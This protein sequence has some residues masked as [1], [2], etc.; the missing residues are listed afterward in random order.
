M[1]FRP[2]LA[3]CLFAVIGI[4]S[5]SQPARCLEVIPLL[6]SQSYVAL[7]GFLGLGGCC[8]SGTLRT[9]VGGIV[10]SNFESIG[11]W[12]VFGMS[13]IK[14]NE[15]AVLRPV[16]LI[17]EEVK[18]DPNLDSSTQ[19]R[20]VRRYTL[21]WSYGVGLFTHNTRTREFDLATLVTGISAISHFEFQYSLNDQFSLVGV[22][23]VGAGLSFDDQGAILN[24]MLGVLWRL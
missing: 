2:S 19:V 15:V 6:T 24:P 7:D 22:A 14:W 3:A 17:G 18:F 23:R 5:F 16:Y 10:R 13:D 11:T 12:D 20:R 21:I 4:L 1:S 8:K 9:G